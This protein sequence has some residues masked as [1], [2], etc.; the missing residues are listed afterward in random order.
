MDAARHAAGDRHRIALIVKIAPDMD[1]HGLDGVIAVAQR[2]GIDGLT[3]AN[4]TV[5][6]PLTL[7][8]Q[9]R[10]E[11]GGLSGKPLFRPSTRMLAMTYERVGETLPL[12]GVGGVASAE[13]AIAKVEAGATLVQL[14]TALIYEGP[15][16]IGTIKAGLLARMRREGLTSLAQMRGRKAAE[17][18][19]A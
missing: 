15:E 7:R 14:Y 10:A 8:G 3:V 1:E 9:S 12:I 11:T 5:A 6:R 17:W 4:T 2:R 19:K 16:L 18:A 13:D